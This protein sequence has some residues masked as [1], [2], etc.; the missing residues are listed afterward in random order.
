MHDANF[1]MLLSADYTEDA[2][3]RYDAEVKKLQRYYQ[4]NK[5][6]FQKVAKRE[7]IWQQYLA[8]EVCIRL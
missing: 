5:T 3:N 4:D 8:Y 1:A 2:L 6:V 7:G